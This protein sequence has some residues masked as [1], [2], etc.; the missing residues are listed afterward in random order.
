M[1][2]LPLCTDR[3]AHANSCRVLIVLM[4]FIIWCGCSS[5]KYH[6]LLVPE[7]R[8]SGW[9]I[10][11][12][13][14]EINWL[15]AANGDSA[16]LTKMTR[17]DSRVQFYTNFKRDSGNW[18][19]EL[20]VRA[21]RQ[22]SSGSTPTMF[23]GEVRFDSLSIITEDD[24][25]SLFCDKMH[26]KRFYYSGSTYAQIEPIP[27]P[28]DAKE[29]TLRLTVSVRSSASSATWDRL[30]LNLPVGLKRLTITPLNPWP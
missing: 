23:G 18:Y 20:A 6:D 29:A 8:T 7:Y 30:S 9:V 17:D 14:D 25:V 2:R 22:T 3:G 12:Q 1:M 5:V 16:S 11:C 21:E 19:Y 4:V 10:D 27:I 28:A 24:E 13:M 26:Q 15:A